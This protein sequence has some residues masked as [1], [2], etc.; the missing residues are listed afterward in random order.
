MLQ[1]K[2]AKKGIRIIM[3]F[4]EFSLRFEIPSIALVMKTFA[5]VIILAF[6][7]FLF[8]VLGYMIV[9]QVSN[10]IRND[11]VSSMHYKKFTSHREDIYPTFSICIASYRG[12]LFKDALGVNTAEI[13]VTY[14]KGKMKENGLIS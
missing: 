5:K 3:Q 1:K 12:G 7:L 14:L 6:K 4:F 10:Y 11:D 8:F 13:Y 9:E 2:E